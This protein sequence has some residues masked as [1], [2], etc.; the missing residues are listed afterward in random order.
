MMAG[1]LAGLSVLELEALGPVPFC[2]MLLGDMGA[3]V[4]RVDRVSAAQLGF[5]LPPDH[6]LR[7]RNKR[8]VAIDLKR[9]EGVGA[10]MRL[11][12]RADVLLE[13]F[14]P[15]VAERLGIGPEACLARRPQ[16]VY[17]RATGWGR[18]GPMSAT[19]G[20]DINYLALTGALDMIGP[21]GGAPVPPLNLVGDYGG[22]AL[23][24]AFGVICA[25]LEAR[26][27]GR[28]QV[29]D[30][31]M[32]DGVT[33]LLTIFHGLRQLGELA[34]GR[35]RN[36]LDGGAPYYTLYEAQGGGYMAVG[37]IEPRFF[38]ALLDRLGLNRAELPDQNDV[39]RWPE[40]R[41]RIAERFRTRTRD[42]WA[43][44]FAGSD[45]CV[46]PV[47][48]LQ[49]AA[50]HPHNT[51]REV[52]IDIGGVSH[53]RPAPRLSRTPG[54]IHRPAPHRAQHTR[55]ALLD[56]GFGEG[57]IAEGLQQGIFATA[58]GINTPP[59]RRGS[60]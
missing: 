45:A 20:H 17:G 44:H 36:V 19:A 18:G 11:A 14:R 2:G 42:E 16:L 46:S 29:V 32:V 54:A 60:E 47:L 56:W 33:S 5:D 43:E 48:S 40:L 52:L 10:L 3:D 21:A 53:P 4:L 27:S 26:A 8:S 41:A 6:D 1:P 34:P 9:P 22:G 28:G 55:E 7:N 23:Y 58:H 12:E 13:G 24:L 37:A 30:L 49:E 50:T 59:P 31:A 25:V 51:A 35:G 38:A 15:G 57:E 39:A